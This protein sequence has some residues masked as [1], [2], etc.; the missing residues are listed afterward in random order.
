MG[1]LTSRPSDYTAAG[2]AA[3][4]SVLTFLCNENQ[5][6]NAQGLARLRAARDVLAANLKPA[7]TAA[8]EEEAAMSQRF[9]YDSGYY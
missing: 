7:R 6:L 8:E 4:S 2:C 1:G 5:L 9:G 3:D